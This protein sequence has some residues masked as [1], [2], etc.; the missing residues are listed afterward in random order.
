MAWGNPLL[1][2]WRRGCEKPTAAE[3][4]LEPAIAALGERY[5]HQYPFWNLKYFADFALLDRKLIIEVDGS[6]HDKPEQKEKDLRHTLEV[7]K[8]GWIVVRTTNE[9]ALKDPAWAVEVALADG[10]DFRYR[11]GLESEYRAALDRLH[12]DY[13]H[14]LA[15]AAKKATRRSQLAKAAAGRRAQARDK[16]VTPDQAKSSRHPSPR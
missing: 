5:R 8:E 7:L 9:C 3:A 2:Y 6:S 10:E 13:P 12:R 4:A 14:L 1:T 11:D 16:R 15:V